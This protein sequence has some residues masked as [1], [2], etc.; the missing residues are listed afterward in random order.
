MKIKMQ[1]R[2]KIN[3]SRTSIGVNDKLNL[4]SIHQCER[5]FRH[6]SLLSYL[7]DTQFL[8][9]FTQI[10]KQFPEQGLKKPFYCKPA[11]HPC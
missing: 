5:T 1:I 7:Y 6:I 2:G 10:V 8:V 11:Y 3:D 4:F 9:G